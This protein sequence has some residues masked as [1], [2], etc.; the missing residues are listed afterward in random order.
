[1]ADQFLIVISST[2][3]LHLHVE[4][5]HSLKVHMD[6]R[7]PRFTCNKILL[8]VHICMHIHEHT[9]VIHINVCMHVYVCIYV[10]VYINMCVYKFL[11]CPPATHFIPIHQSKNIELWWYT[12]RNEIWLLFLRRMKKMVSKNS[13]NFEK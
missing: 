6:S 8:C 12:C 1:M 5:K 9:Y 7:M 11:H 2:V 10:C 3:R 13:K 4:R